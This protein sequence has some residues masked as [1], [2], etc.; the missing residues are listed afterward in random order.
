VRGCGD[1]FTADL[2]NS[3]EYSSETLE[4]R[5]GEGFHGKSLLP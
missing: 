3:S 5:R 2:G 4:G 1:Y